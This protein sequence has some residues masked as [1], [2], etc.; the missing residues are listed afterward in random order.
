MTRSSLSFLTELGRSSGGVVRFRILN[1]RFVA[2][3][4]PECAHRIL[5]SG[6]DHY[7]RSFHSKNLGIIVGDGL[8]SSEGAKWKKN[9][10]QLQPQFRPDAMERLV[11][12][13]TRAVDQLLKHWEA[14]R[15]EGR[16]LPVVTD[17][18]R[19]T[20]SAMARILFS[21]DI[22][23]EDAAQ[24]DAA[25]RN[26]EVR[27]RKRNTAL[28][29][30]PVWM[31]TAN[32]RS[33]ARSR[34]VLDEFIER[35]IVMRTE[36]LRPELPDMFEALL[37]A[38]DP[39]TGE[40]LTHQELV[41]QCKTILVAGYETTGLGLTWT[42]YLLARHPDVA[43]RMCEEADQVLKGLPPA[44]RDL[45]KLT[46]AAQVIHESL[47]LYPPVYAIGRECIKDDEMQGHIVRKG[48]VLLI[49]T[50]GMQRSNIWG[51]DFETFRP[52]RFAPGCVWPR[53]AFLPFGSGRH[54]CLGNAFAVTE[55]MISVTIIC[56]RY[57]L[58]PV[59]DRIVEPRGEIGLVPERE[60]ELRLVPR[61][62][63]ATGIRQA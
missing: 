61:E 41:D 47:R 15:L 35:Q 7:D 56:Q 30:F 57:R 21:I 20:L 27:L 38:R 45:P 34:A 11:P 8:L 10:S 42:L 48:W 13:V 2:V 31:P 22:S 37:E 23:P 53:Q 44:W 50:F 4:D 54:V 55:M 62:S 59:D 19:L 24:V 39:D 6:V 3:A 46:Y 12:A 18:R 28:V 9:R 14:A 40:G 58:Q 33:L 49:S 52:E 63:R 32:N 5:V 51:E 16:S 25:I 36:G 43:S 1:R 26:G 29:Q 17:M 60:I